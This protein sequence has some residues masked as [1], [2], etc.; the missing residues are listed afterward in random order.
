MKPAAMLMSHDEMLIFIDTSLGLDH[1]PPR[2]QTRPP[3][4]R[5]STTR[6]LDPLPLSLP[7]KRYLRPVSDSQT[8]LIAVLM[9]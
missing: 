7:P 9:D 1:L 3:N 6:K 4:V 8:D 2:D 5:S